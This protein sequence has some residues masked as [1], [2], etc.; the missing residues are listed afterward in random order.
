MQLCKLVESRQIEE[1]NVPRSPFAPN[2]EARRVRA[3]QV[4]DAWNVRALCLVNYLELG[5]P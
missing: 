4:G 1:A 5:T 2:Y 3:D